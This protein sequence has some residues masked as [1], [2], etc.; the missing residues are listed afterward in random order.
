MG[1]LEILRMMA[2]M[3]EWEWPEDT[4]LMVLQALRDDRAEVRGLAAGHAAG[5][6]DDEVGGELL[7]VLRGDGDPGVRAAAAT[8]FG[9]ALEECDA[10]EVALGFDEDL[11]LSRYLFVEVRKALHQ[12]YCSAEVPDLVRRRAIEAAVRAPEPWLDGAARAAF[13]SG[14][15][16]WRTTAV[17]CMGWLDGHEPSILEALEDGDIDV[18]REAI[19]AAGRCSLPQAC[20]ELMRVAGT[21]AFERSLRL[22]AVESL[23]F[24]ESPAAG[25]LLQLI[26]R[27]S[28]VE[29]ADLAGWALEQRELFRSSGDPDDD[30]DGF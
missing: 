12:V 25:D 21:P 10:E 14:D 18:R 9:P 23:A 3:P 20:P 26:S 24:M 17:F 29:L 1:H 7:R 11:P 13:A 28:D 19:R 4:R 6:M 2:D 15:A 8:S 27:G 30:W 16:G 22:V 5:V